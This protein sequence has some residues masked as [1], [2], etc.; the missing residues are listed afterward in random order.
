MLQ[1]KSITDTHPIGVCTLRELLAFSSNKGAARVG[2]AMGGDALVASL[3]DFGFGRPTGVGLPAEGHGRLRSAGA[4][5]PLG[6]ANVSFGQGISTTALQLGMAVGALGNDGVLMK[7]RLVARVVDTHGVPEWV[8]RPE[9]VRSVVSPQAAR[10]VVAMM[11]GVTEDPGATGHEA[12]VLGVRVAGKTGTAQKPRTDGRGYGAGRLASFV[13]LVPA[14]EPALAIVVIVD[15]PSAGSH[16]GGV[17]AAPVV[18]EIASGAMAH[19]GLLPA[20]DVRQ[21]LASAASPSLRG[22]AEIAIR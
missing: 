14:E 19:L 20:P 18:A 13:A 17:V 5:G 7:P 16:A 15:E 2:M 12:R 3:R 1:G 4:L 10:A 21:A 9:A 6:L 8:S 22:E 11:V